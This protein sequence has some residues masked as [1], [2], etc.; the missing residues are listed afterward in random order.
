M[1]KIIYVAESSRHDG[2]SYE[3]RVT[4]DKDEAISAAENA[5]NCL[6]DY[7]RVR[8]SHSVSGYEVEVQ[9]GQTAKEAWH[10]YVMNSAWISDPIF[11]QEITVKDDEE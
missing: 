10:E 11:W 7:D 8:Q 2:D 1:K 5:R 9:D 3:D 4:F 6:S